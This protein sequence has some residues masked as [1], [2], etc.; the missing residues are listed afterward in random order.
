MCFSTPFFFI[1]PSA[2]I[3]IFSSWFTPN[4]TQSTN[5][6]CSY[7]NHHHATT[8]P[9]TLSDISPCMFPASS[10]QPSPLFHGCPDCCQQSS[11]SNNTIDWS[12]ATAT[13]VG[14]EE[15]WVQEKS[16]VGVRDL[17][18]GTREESGM[19]ICFLKP[20]Q[21]LL[22]LIKVNSGLILDGLGLFFK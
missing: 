1:I 20:F 17:W 2:Q 7:H 11:V 4:L 5:R 3:F 8:T 19:S 13:K 6:F 15:M 16:R 22:V 21:V 9:L 18:E 10:T 14:T 12:H